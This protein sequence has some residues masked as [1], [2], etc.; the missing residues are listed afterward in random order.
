M[1]ETSTKT[2][3]ERTKPATPRKRS[4]RVH[5]HVVNPRSTLEALRQRLDGMPPLLVVGV[6]VAAG[7]LAA[8]LLASDSVARWARLVPGLVAATLPAWIEA[9]GGR[10]GMRCAA[11]RSAG[12]R[13]ER[14]AAVSPGARRA[15]PR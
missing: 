8:R 9:A 11:R 1:P 10:A 15:Q 2:R 3:L 7:A 14:R 4:R 12:G 5:A 13:R 6:G